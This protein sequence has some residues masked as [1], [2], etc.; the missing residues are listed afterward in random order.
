M[1]EQILDRI[2][3]ALEA[4]VIIMS[5]NAPSSGSPKPTTDQPAAPAA[6]DDFLGGDTPAEETL[7]LQ[8]VL[9]LTKEAAARVGKEKVIALIKKFKATKASEIP[10]DKFEKYVDELTKLKK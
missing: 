7:D 9:E 2:A 10:E 5:Q 4:L 3:N 8:K 1:L 6:D